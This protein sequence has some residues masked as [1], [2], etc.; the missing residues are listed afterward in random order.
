MVIE[1]LVFTMESSLVKDAKVF[2]SEA[3]AIKG[4]TVAPETVIVSCQENKE[5][6]ANIVDFLNAFKW[7]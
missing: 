3:Y 4:F 7:G 6:V 5:I 1:P 2:L